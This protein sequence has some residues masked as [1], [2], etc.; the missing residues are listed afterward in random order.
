MWKL[1]CLLS[2]INYGIF[3]EISWQELCLSYYSASAYK[4][5]IMR[6]WT[7][8]YTG[9]LVDKQSIFWQ[10]E[11]RTFICFAYKNITYQNVLGFAKLRVNKR[12]CTKQSS[13]KA[14]TTGRKRT[15]TS[16]GE[17]GGANGKAGKGTE[18]EVCSFWCLSKVRAQI[19]CPKEKG[20][21]LPQ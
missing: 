5:H 17:M 19:P 11:E 14:F 3:F 8:S 10:I 18:A 12:K 21:P 1:F 6:C 15:G 13:T 16:A 9:H 2:L 7:I 20:Q 4:V